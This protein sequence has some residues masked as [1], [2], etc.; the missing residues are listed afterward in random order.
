LRAYTDNKKVRGGLDSEIAKGHVAVAVRISPET[1]VGGFVLPGSR[2]N[3]IHATRDGQKGSEAKRILE[4]ILVKAID[5][6]PMHPAG[7]P[8]MVGATATLEVTP[9]EGL[10]LVSV[11]GTGTVSLEL[12]PSSDKKKINR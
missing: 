2:V 11:Q 3:V 12:R 1:G 9:E 6:L 10:K 5:L 8:G 7:R 4:N